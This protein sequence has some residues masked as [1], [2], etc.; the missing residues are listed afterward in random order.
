[1]LR[2]KAAKIVPQLARKLVLP[3]SVEAPEEALQSFVRTLSR[4]PKDARAAA[5]FAEFLRDHGR[6]LA[7]IDGLEGWCL[8][9]DPHTRELE[10]FVFMHIPK[11]AGSVIRLVVLSLFDRG[12]TYPG[13]NY[14]DLDACHGHLRDHFDADKH[15]VFVGHMYW[16][17]VQFVEDRLRCKAN[18]FA[19][20]RDPLAHYRSQ[21]SFV[22]ALADQGITETK[23]QGED[24]D[25]VDFWDDEKRTQFG[26]ACFNLQIASFLANDY[27]LD[28][29]KL[30]PLEELMPN[31]L[32]KASERLDRTLIGFAEDLRRT[33]DLLSSELKLPYQPVPNVRLNPSHA[34]H[35]Q[36]MSNELKAQVDRYCSVSL[37]F[38]AD[39]RRRFDD[40]YKSAF[41]GIDD[42]PGHLNT[43]YRRAVL[44]KLTPTWCVHL[45]A[46]YAW[47]G[48]GWGHRE[49]R[50]ALS[51]RQLSPC[52]QSALFARLHQGSDFVVS[53]T[54]FSREKPD[55]LDRIVATA[56]GI[57]LQ[58]RRRT[59][60]Q[61]LYMRAWTLPGECMRKTGG[62]V[63]LKFELPPNKRGKRP[64]ISIDSIDIY[65]INE[66]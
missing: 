52:G 36:P 57:R 62:A 28:A 54:V 10:P 1:V 56:N 31:V 65:P 20:L 41:A 42:V 49:T 13:W 50:G 3:S 46:D 22:D 27:P 51:W 59:F 43:A 18:V 7:S 9:T 33:L 16:D 64:Y 26:V 55:A 4:K 19:I 38:D 12:R 48:Y 6:S 15:K 24:F 5:A 29:G 44:E 66:V 23:T 39:A 63:E 32:E 17:T 25:F 14:E 61:S 30:A 2:R 60:L 58:P 40:A 35:S 45:Q 11:T 47:P 34:D 53:I 21:L 8:T 37:E